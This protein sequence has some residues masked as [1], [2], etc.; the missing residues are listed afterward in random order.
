M[1]NPLLQQRSSTARSSSPI[2][3]STIRLAI[4]LITAFIFGFAICSAFFLYH[5]HVND[6]LLSNSH[7][8]HYHG[9]APLIIPGSRG[10]S[11]SSSIR[12]SEN[13]ISSSSS[14][15]SSSSSTSI[16][17]GLRVL[18]TIVSFDFM[19]LSHLE[20]VLDGFYDLCY[21]GSKVDIVVYTTVLVSICMCCR[22][23]MFDRSWKYFVHILCSLLYVSLYHG[24]VFMLNETAMFLSCAHFCVS[25]VWYGIIE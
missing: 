21:A 9:N 13:S 3:V 16:L 12:N 15:V 2:S 23:L 10:I 8:P 4:L 5:T 25:L 22:I 17:D 18:V 20:E 6:P 7:L 14:V 11:K 1:A 24:I 19:Q